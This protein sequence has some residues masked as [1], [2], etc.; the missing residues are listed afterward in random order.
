MAR[1]SPGASPDLPDFANRPHLRK[2]S[3]SPCSNDNTTAP[4]KPLRVLW[5]STGIFAPKLRLFVEFS[6]GEPYPPP[7]KASRRVNNFLKERL[8]APNHLNRRA[9]RRPRR[10]RQRRANRT[11]S[12]AWRRKSWSRV[13]GIEPLFSLERV[14]A[15]LNT[16]KGQFGQRRSKRYCTGK[17]LFRLVELAQAPGSAD[18]CRYNIAISLLRKILRIGGHS[19]SSSAFSKWGNSTLNRVNPS[20]WPGPSDFSSR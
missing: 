13:K 9:D 2:S 17:W 11:R 3:S 7:W 20:L 1:A 14:L 15:N 18:S 5:P 4:E 12:S 19:N 16:F 6:P 8:S 10:T